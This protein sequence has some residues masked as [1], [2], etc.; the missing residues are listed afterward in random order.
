MQDFFCIEPTKMHYQELAKR[1]A[2]FNT[3]Q[4]GMKA[5]CEIMQKLHDE[6]REEGRIVL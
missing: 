5:M 6:G 4:R 3:N 1:T 2:F